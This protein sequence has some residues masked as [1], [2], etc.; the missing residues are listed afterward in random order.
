MR[1]N[2]SSDGGAPAW[3][4]VLINALYVVCALAGIVVGLYGLYLLVAGM[5]IVEGF[6]LVGLAFGLLLTG[7]GFGLFALALN[8]LT[9]AWY[10]DARYKTRTWALALLGLVGIVVVGYFAFVSLRGI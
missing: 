5:I 7:A 3:A 8:L 10:R 9:G 4:R 2:P 1:D 6:D